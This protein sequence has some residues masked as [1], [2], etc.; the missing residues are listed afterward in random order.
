MRGE[1]GWFT[2][3]IFWEQRGVRLCAC[4][5]HIHTQPCTH[6]Q[7]T[8]SKIARHPKHSQQHPSTNLS[9]NDVRNEDGLC[10]GSGIRGSG[11]RIC[12]R[13]SGPLR[14]PV[15]GIGTGVASG[16][17]G[18]GLLHKQCGLVLQPWHLRD[19]LCVDRSVVASW[20]KIHVLH[21]FSAR[22]TCVP[23]SVRP[24][25]D[26][27]EILRYSC[28]V[29]WQRGG[30]RLQDIALSV[31]CLSRRFYVVRL[32]GMSLCSLCGS[33]LSTNFLVYLAL[34]PL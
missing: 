24:S 14:P 28:A 6:T 34:P 29:S 30:G 13:S 15:F 21:M 33:A 2:D 19:A 12:S 11:E 25:R 26:G 18:Y 7:P 8:P 5:S 32:R 1:I 17:T 20:L 31:S 22:V 4:A 9:T 10:G 23:V 3:S 16:T 27:P